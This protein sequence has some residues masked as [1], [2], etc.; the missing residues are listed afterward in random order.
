MYERN[1]DNGVVVTVC[2][3]LSLS[4]LFCD[5]AIMTPKTLSGERFC[6]AISTAIMG[7]AIA[8]VCNTET[9]IYIGRK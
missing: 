3:Y 4:L 2:V 9:F 8:G 6:A 5:V 7:V 1:R